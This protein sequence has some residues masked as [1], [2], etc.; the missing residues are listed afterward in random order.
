MRSPRTRVTG[1]TR[2]VYFTR[3]CPI[4]P[5]DSILVAERPTGLLLER[6]SVVTGL[7]N[8]CRKF[9][10]KRYCARQAALGFKH[11]WPIP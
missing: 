6:P 4:R 11:C 7:V 8:Y 2:P 1:A 9:W 10:S 5:H 3:E